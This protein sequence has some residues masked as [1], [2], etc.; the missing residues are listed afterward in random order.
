MRAWPKRVSKGGTSRIDERI[1]CGSRALRA[2]NAVSR[3]SISTTPLAKSACTRL[4]IAWNSSSRRFASVISGTR[5]S[6]TGR[7]VSKVAARIGSTAFLLA[8]G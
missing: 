1:A 5:S 4:P 7:R 2:S 6:R 3:C 8:E